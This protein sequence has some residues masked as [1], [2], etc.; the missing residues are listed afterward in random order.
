[1]PENHLDRTA[2]QNLLREHSVTRSLHHPTL[3]IV[4]NLRRL[5]DDPELHKNAGLALIFAD[6]CEQMQQLAFV[7]RIRETRTNERPVELDHPRGEDGSPTFS[8]K[9]ADL[10]NEEDMSPTQ[11]RF[12][13]SFAGD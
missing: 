6:F 12:M 13:R 9:P 11:R 7:A 8:N 5:R 1:M 10:P 2:V 4:D 3:M